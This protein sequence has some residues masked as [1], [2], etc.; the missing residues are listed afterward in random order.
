VNIYDPEGTLREEMAV[1]YASYR[2]RERRGLSIRYVEES[3]PTV[4]PT[5]DPRWRSYFRF[6]ALLHRHLERPAYI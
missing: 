5:R 2:E 3:A 6:E 4:D 1:R